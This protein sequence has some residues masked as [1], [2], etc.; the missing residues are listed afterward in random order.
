[1]VRAMDM[2]TRAADRQPLIV[3]A[4]SPQLWLCRYWRAQP[5]PI[6]APKNHTAIV[7]CA[8][9]GGRQECLSAT[10]GLACAHLALRICRPRNS[11]VLG[12][13]MQAFHRTA[14]ICSRF[15][16]STMC[17]CTERFRVR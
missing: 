5:P 14:M 2:V 3:R 8:T 17:G 11:K 9:D 15:I 12:D 6:A 10:N 7:K 4:R 16:K 13:A 1:M